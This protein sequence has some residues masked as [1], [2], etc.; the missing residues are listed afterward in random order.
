[1][2]FILIVAACIV[3]I[4]AIYIQK[5]TA[6]YEEIKKFKSI[7][8]EIEI[9]NF[10]S[11]HGLYGFNY[12]DV[13]D[14]TCFNFGLTSQNFSYDYR[15]LYYY[16]DKISKDAIVFIPISYFSFWVDETTDDDFLSKNQRYY[17]FLP[18]NLIKEYDIKTDFYEHY[19]PSLKAYGKIW[20]VL[21]TKQE[22]N[23]AAI[24][25]QTA[26]SINLETDAMAAY[27]RHIGKF[28][29]EDGNRVVNQDELD[30][31]YNIIDLCKD[32][33][34]TPILVTTPYLSEYT[35]IIE[36]NSPEFYIEFYGLLNT[37]VEE[38]GVAYYDY[39]MDERFNTD[40][41]LFSNADHLNRNGAKKFVEILLDEVGINS[42]LSVVKYF[43]ESS[44]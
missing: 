1:M 35:D 21:F 33:G 39:A 9:C 27:T 17:K 13:E 24:E 16:Q 14:Y 22:D 6:Y 31:L 29:D 43:F 5:D 34:V 2:V 44:L 36:K 41:S 15:I 38:K 18:A 19:F 37:I 20:T 4:N 42:Q 8:S 25:E 12:D 26:D 10:G 23:E 11:S 28:L 3:V 32:I 7:P 30:A 40:Y